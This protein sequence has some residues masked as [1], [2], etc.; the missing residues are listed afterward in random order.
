MAFLYFEDLEVG[1]T[2]ALGSVEVSE[3]DV[4]DFAAQWDPQ[5]MHLTHEA[6]AESFF[7]ELT[8]SG[9]QTCCLLMRRMCDGLLLQAA[10]KGSPGISQLRWRKPVRPGDC[11]TMQATV[12]AARPS[13]SRPEIG[14]ITFRFDVDNDRGE[15][16][17]TMEN[18]IM[19]G[20]RPAENVS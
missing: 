5:P 9:W 18:T 10:S 1:D 3:A 13:R 16:V 12:V 7:G 20:R 14:L 4:V 6:A 8:A 11:L 15:Q 17:M 2:R 19:L